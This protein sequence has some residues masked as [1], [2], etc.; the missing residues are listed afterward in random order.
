MELLSE[1][2]ELQ[3]TCRQEDSQSEEQIGEL[4]E[5]VRDLE[6]LNVTWMKC[7][8]APSGLRRGSAVIDIDRHIV[9]FSNYSDRVYAYQW[10]RKEWSKLPD[11]PQ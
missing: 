10:Q 11:C 3:A 4:L 6:N 2:S 7:P 8:K 9:Y 1:S 5:I